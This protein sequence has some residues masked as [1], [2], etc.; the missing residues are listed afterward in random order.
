MGE[1]VNQES[2]V[3]MAFLQ[4]C[5]V[6]C[7]PGERPA[8]GTFPRLRRATARLFVCFGL[9][10]FGPSCTGTFGDPCG[11]RRP[12]DNMCQK[13]GLLGRSGVQSLGESG[14]V[15]PCRTSDV[16]RSWRSWTEATKRGATSHLGLLFVALLQAEK[17]QCFYPRPG[18]RFGDL[19]CIVDGEKMTQSP[20]LVVYMDP[21]L[22]DL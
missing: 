16:R 14:R 20:G 18:G 9:D 2:T 10:M 12:T 11:G 15:G 1:F 7:R 19:A 17:V 3:Y 5:L 4:K 22:K 21:D 6:T 8:L 13:D